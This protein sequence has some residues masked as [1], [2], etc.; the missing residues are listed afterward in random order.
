MENEY[1][2]EIDIPVAEYLEPDIVYLTPDE[3]D[4]IRDDIINSVTD[5]I[6]ERV[7]PIADSLVDL[8]DG[9]NQIIE[10]AGASTD[11]TDVEELTPDSLELELDGEVLEVAPT[12]T[13]EPVVTYQQ[14]EDIKT[15]LSNVQ[16]INLANGVLLAL[17]AGCIF[18]G[19]LWRSLLR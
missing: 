4:S 16:T 2:P 3:I 17:L 9:L 8:Q 18:V 11:S 19:Q 14:V 7:D 1:Y 13:P 12:A 5:I 15:S 6:D 10:T